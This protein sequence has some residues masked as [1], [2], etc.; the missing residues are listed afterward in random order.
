[1]VVSS[2]RPLGGGWRV[3]LVDH[4]AAAG[5]ADYPG[6]HIT[7]ASC[8]GTVPIINAI[9]TGTG[10]HANRKAHRCRACDADANAGH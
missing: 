10:R 1:M 8:P 7:A 3:P 4:V 6:I 2:A 5:V 9:D